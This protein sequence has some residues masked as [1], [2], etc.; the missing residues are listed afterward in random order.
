MIQSGDLI[1]VVFVFLTNLGIDLAYRA[2]NPQVDL[3]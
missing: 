3:G 1:L 2:L